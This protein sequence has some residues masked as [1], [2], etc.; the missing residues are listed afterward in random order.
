MG[1]RFIDV[2]GRVNSVWSEV[3]LQAYLAVAGRVLVLGPPVVMGIQ[4][5]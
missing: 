5:V 1:R 2:L 3:A 4:D